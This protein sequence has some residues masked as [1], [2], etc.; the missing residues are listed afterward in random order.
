MCACVVDSALAFYLEIRF[1]HTLGRTQHAAHVTQKTF[2][3]IMR[4]YCGSVNCMHETRAARG[5]SW[6]CD[7]WS[8]G[9]TDART[10][11]TD[12]TD[13]DASRAAQHETTAAIVMQNAYSSEYGSM[14]SRLV[15]R[16]ARTF[17]LC[18]RRRR[19]RRCR[20]M[21]GDLCVTRRRRCGCAPTWREQ[22]AAHAHCRVQ[23]STPSSKCAVGF[24]L[25]GCVATSPPPPPLA[26]IAT[27][28]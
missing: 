6:M 12:A 7:V 9:R 19:R 26:T 22:F 10:V 20:R 28:V 16:H 3:F 25:G 17:A 8:D 13:D 18:S 27:T 23:K 1:A 5:H 11:A 21:V 15:Q 24:S 2:P 14:T 4:L